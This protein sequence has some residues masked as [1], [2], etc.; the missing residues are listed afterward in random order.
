VTGQ[1]NQFTAIVQ[2]L[3]AETVNV[4]VQLGGVDIPAVAGGTATS[5]P[6][7][8]EFTAGVPDL[9]GGAEVEMWPTADPSST[10]PVTAN[11]S[12]TY[13]LR[14]TVVDGNG[15]PLVRTVDF[16][17]TVG[18]GSLSAANCATSTSGLTPGQCTVTLR[19]AK[20]GPVAV[21]ATVAEG[22]LNHSPVTGQFVAGAISDA[23]SHLTVEPASQS[24]GGYVT[25]TVH[26][27]DAQNNPID[28]LTA[29][30][31]NV[32]AASG[33][34]PVATDPVAGQFFAAGNGDYTFQLTAT[35][36]AAYQ[37][38]ATVDGLALSEHPSVTF[39]A[40]GVCVTG[41][42][43]ADPN[44]VTRAELVDN[45]QLANG[46]AQDTALV[47]AYDRYGNA[48][49]GATV[50]AAAINSANLTPQLATCQ[51]A[52]NGTCQLAWTSA[53]AGAYGATVRVDGLEFATSQLSP[54][55]F[56]AG[57]ADPT[58][59]L[60]AVNPASPITV[61]SD[62][63]LLATI[64]DGQGNPVTGEAVLFGL[65]GANAGSA[66]LTPD[67][68]TTNSAGQCQVSL[69]A[70]LADAYT[71]SAQVQTAT[72]LAHI[73]QSPVNLAFTATGVCT[74]NCQPVDPSH[75]T[76][77]E[78]TLDGQPVTE[79]NRLTLYAYDY[80]G[81]PVAGA[82]VVIHPAA[83][84]TLAPNT[85]AVT[86]ND[87]RLTIDLTSAVAGAHS[88]TVVTVAGLDPAGSPAT[89]TWA[90]GAADAT[91][92][93]LTKS[94]AGAL[95]VDEDFTLT[96]D[97]RDAQGNTVDGAVVTFT[98]AAGAE[99]VG[100]VDRCV[101]VGGICQ[102]QV[103][104]TQ[105]GSFDVAAN[106]PLASLTGS[107]V[108]VE[109][110]AGQVCLPAAG[111]TPDRG[112]QTSRVELI[113]NGAAPDGVDRDIVE[114]FAFDQHGNPVQG[115]PVDSLPVDRLVDLTV[116]PV[117]EPTNN[118]GLTTIWYT[119][120]TAGRHWAEVTINGVAVPGSPVPLEYG[121]GRGYAANSSYTITPDVPLTV[122]STAA[123]TYTVAAAIN[124]V[125]NQPVTDSVVT[126]RLGSGQSGP[127][128]PNGATCRTDSD[129]HCTVTLYSTV[130][131]T[132]TIA[133]MID[134]GSIGSASS[135]S[136][137]PEAVCGADCTPEPG[138]GPEQRTRVE[139][140]VDHQEA[141]GYAE[142]VIQAWGFDRYGNPAVG[143][144][145]VPTTPPE[146]DANV[147]LVGL[148]NNGQASIRFSSITA[149]QHTIALT[150][151]GMNPVG[152]P[153][154]IT[155]EP[156]RLS[157]ANSTVTVNPASQVVDQP[158]EVK[159]HLA[160]AFGNAVDGQPES[161][162][163]VVAQPATATRARA[164]GDLTPTNFTALGNGDYTWQL[165]SQQAE[166]YVLSATVDGVVLTQH[167]SVTFTA[168]TVCFVTSQT[169]CSGDPATTSRVEVTADNQLADGQASDQATVRLFDQHGNP[170]T[171]AQVTSQP[172]SADLTVSA[173]APTDTRGQTVISYQTM[174]MGDHN[175]R[176]FVT[177]NGQPVEII[178]Y[179]QGQIVAAQSS[180]V[181]LHF[182]RSDAVPAPIITEPS[183]QTPIGTQ[184]P[185][186]AGTGE[187]GDTVTILDQGTAI[188]T[189]IVGPNG[190]WTWTPTTPLDEGTHV[191]TAQQTDS[192]GNVSPPSAS[193]TITIDVTP[194]PAPR[195]DQPVNG[196]EINTDR[197]LVSGS[198]D[199]GTTVTADAGNG[200]SCVAVADASGHYQCQLPQPLPQGPATITVTATDV[201][202]NVSPP[203]VVETTVDLTPPTA[204]RVDQPVNGGEIN[205]VRPEVSGQAEPGSTVTADAGNGNTCTAVADAVTGLY[206]CQ[207]PSD[208]PQGPAT[209]TVTATDPAG[210]V[211]PPTV[212]E[213]TVDLDP[214]TAPR[215]D[216]PVNGG[217]IN[218]VRPEVSGQAE[219]GSTVTAD[220]GNGNSCTAVADTSGH[221]QCQLPNDLPEGPAT[222]TVT[223]TD[224]AGNVSPPTVVET[225]VD[226]DPPLAPSVDQPV[227]GQPINT[228]QPEISGTAE[229]GSLVT[230]DA[231]NGNTCLA[232]AD[233]VSGHYQCQ[234]PF[235]LPEGPATITVTATDPAGNVSPPTVVET[236]VDT[237]PPLSPVVEH[238]TPGESTNDRTPTVSGTAEPGTSVTVDAGGGNTCVAIADAMSGHFECA[239]PLPLGDGPAEVTVTA[240][241]PAGNASPPVVIDFTVDTAPV[242]LVVDHP[243]DGETINTNKPQVSGTAKSG[244][245]VT[246]DAG[247]GNICTAVAD[248]NG[249][250]ACTVPQPL[251]EGSA[252]IT[253]T[254][255]D[256]AGNIDGPIVI[257][258]TVDTQAPAAPV[259][260]QP[261]SGRPIGTDQPEVSG[262]AE[263]GSTVTVDAGGGNTC[264]AIAD[265]FGNFHCPVPQPLPDGPVTITVTA[266]DPVGNVSPPTVI[267]TVVDTHQ[268]QPP[269][270]E[271]PVDGGA[272]NSPQP[273]VS[274]KAEPG[275]TVTV[276]AGN[277]NTCT[278][279]A[280]ADGNFACQVFSPLP[281]GPVT[282]TVTATD[283]AGNSSEPTVITTTVDTEVPTTPTVDT[284][285]PDR[286]TGTG[287]VGDSITV[288]GGGDTLCTATVDQS[289]NF[290]CSPSRPLQPGEE[291]VVTATD[292]AGNEAV[293]R[294]RVLA[295]T[296]EHPSLLAG[297]T[298]TA[299]GLYFQGT[300]RQRAAGE[301]IRCYVGGTEVATGQA[302][303]DGRATCSWII[304]GDSPIGQYTVTMVGDISGPVRATYQVTKPIPT[305]GS[306]MTARLLFGD[307]TLA[308]LGGVF[309]VAAW[310]RRQEQAEADAAIRSSDH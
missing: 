47:W 224:P 302:D 32:V 14:A 235:P 300:A 172:G 223:A 110:T 201:A 182:L 279:V 309:L 212:V 30:Q 257:T 50:E 118:R 124:D 162:F 170:V 92:S 24:T 59:S 78:V 220:A 44:N 221:Y 168:A 282:I 27:A 286:I 202:G 25:V 167:P 52:A 36:A 298:Q 266:T 43:P 198:A 228:P 88:G 31:F 214:P 183:G 215:V 295:L 169:P 21:S 156:G 20:A 8:V 163:A 84:V 244:S 67:T 142:D 138:V 177:V 18:E 123:S 184:T 131:G 175:A 259:V 116:Q 157:T 61:G 96:A 140:T 277:G 232:I 218:T 28:G 39:T 304:P 11:D 130:A 252:T 217:E 12:D 294:V 210:N 5:S 197:P 305:T 41:C 160:D 136:W 133:P 306:A 234:L 117:I 179:Q 111:C 7:A 71:V 75:Q 146:V 77:L 106:L 79:Y 187:V 276:D 204:P 261:V 113:R 139:V 128:F 91:R 37:M 256:K 194:P 58:Q 165:T 255:D 46:Q 120:Q 23:N 216:E 219:P 225:T 287:D 55:R 265:A 72:G 6:Q 195:V 289:G 126:V 275:S 230:A 151:G 263:P 280:D 51:T 33:A 207:L 155:F 192:L 283:E 17:L 90:T 203:T 152:S 49:G 191:I 109:F 63:H 296:V 260:D 264:T 178:V 10:E 104:S 254:A 148:D 268:P 122:G 239:L 299:I 193:R 246:V 93:T 114:V 34:Q 166:T 70:P 292:A 310:R 297:Q 74:A 82:P 65:A 176:V 251:A 188:G 68:C 81:N 147:P 278:A 293:L 112:V 26:V 53:V 272:V 15:N 267:E 208:L 291:L 2:D 16:A 73:G 238:P 76:R 190:Q 189:A 173:I 38:F 66:E 153:V 209:I 180:P 150:V 29:S 308:G 56:A 54:I 144:A 231:G 85:A 145:V 181:S 103:T 22:A 271:R 60:L 99:F 249:H 158:V 269:V 161:A 9:T 185:Q 42:T 87:G 3:V 284:S 285:D 196:S 200:N 69:S 107:P 101:T 236:T 253:V 86:G 154:A 213:T 159:V 105:V 45:N 62:Y 119:S 40:S 121:N 83:G 273:E 115:V 258:T 94:P 250:F 307:A 137:L 199:A 95:L 226:L 125:F 171:G 262:N 108:R 102:V 135:R 274:G 227:S 141:N 98:A 247:N 229:P 281:D 237:D 100:G 97:V 241:D 127:T 134:V 290:S 143:A 206:Q 222:I 303:S 132:Y 270:V 48:V 149:G 233:A 35:V 89:L 80:F 186:F 57:A 19:S 242:D 243:A 211:S 245:T 248:A 13:T 164:A 4:T 1:A 288:T 301:N 129:G 174:T 64:L 240:T 205:T